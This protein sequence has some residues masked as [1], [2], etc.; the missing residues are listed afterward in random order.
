MATPNRRD[1]NK[2]AAQQG[3]DDW[4]GDALDA[5]D[6]VVAEDVVADLAFPDQVRGCEAYKEALDTYRSAF[7][8]VTP[9]VDDVVAEDDTVVV[10][11][12]DRGTHGGELMGIE[13]TG[14]SVEA[15]GFVLHRF[16]DG[17]IVEVT[18]IGDLFGLMR[19]LG[20]VEPSGE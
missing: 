4:D 7:S 13:P 1:A 8:D 11:Y 3:I 15:S 19:Q 20:V 2:R 14:S 16:E 17:T 12:T 9:E 18:N 10:H 5:P 6:D